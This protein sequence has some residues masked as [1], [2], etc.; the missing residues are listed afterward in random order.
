V[1]LGQVIRHTTIV[2]SDCSFHC[3]VCTNLLC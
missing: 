1:R 2:H 3:M